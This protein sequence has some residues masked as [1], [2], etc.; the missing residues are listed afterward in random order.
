[1]D[2]DFY[3]RMRCEN[4]APGLIEDYLIANREHPNRISSANVDYNYRF[5]HPEGSWI[6]NKEELDYVLEKNKN[7]TYQNEKD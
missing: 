2:T 1:M 3:H 6:V 4:G 7:N 5:D